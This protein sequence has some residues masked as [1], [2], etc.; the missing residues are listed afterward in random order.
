MAVPEDA[1]DTTIFEDEIIDDVAVRV[2]L[3]PEF[4]AMVLALAARLIDGTVSSSI[5]VTV[6][7]DVPMLTP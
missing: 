5:I 2:I 7:E 4:S 3:D 1:R 6:V